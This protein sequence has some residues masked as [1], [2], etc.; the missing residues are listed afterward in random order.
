MATVDFERGHGEGL[1][2]FT[3]PD[4]TERN[5]LVRKLKTLPNKRRVSLLF[6]EGQGDPVF[7]RPGWPDEWLQAEEVA[8]LSWDGGAS[9]A[10]AAW[11]SGRPLK[12]APR[13][14]SRS[15]SRGGR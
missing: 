14:S 13:R 3:A 4:G 11:Y 2:P 7:W 10:F 15:R 9:G 5:L 12:P 1:F 6:E 8:F